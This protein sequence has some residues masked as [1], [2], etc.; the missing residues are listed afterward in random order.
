MARIFERGGAAVVTGAALGIGRAAALRYA[1]LG[2]QVVLVDLPSAELDEAGAAVAAIAGTSATLVVPATVADRAATATLVEAVVRRFGAPTVLMNNA[3]T[4]TGGSVL[5]DIAQWREA[6]EVN[7]WGVVNVV[8][9]FA[10][11]MIS[12]GRPAAIINVGS[13][14]GITN[15]PG[16]AAYN[17]TKAA[18]KSYT[19]QLAHHLRQGAGG[20]VTAHLLVPGWTT[21]GKRDHQ[22]GAWLPDQ[23]IDHMI[24]R[25]EQGSFYIVCPDGEVDAAMDAK[26]IVW[27]ALDITEDRPALSRWHGGF[28]AAF[29]AFASSPPDLATSAMSADQ[30]IAMLGLVPHPEGGAYRETFRDAEGSG[31]RSHSTAIYFLLRKGEVSRWHR[32]DAA[33]IWHHYSGAP[34][35]LS[36][37]AGDGV[38]ASTRSDITLGSAVATGARPQAIVPAGAW[39]Q[40]RSLGDW[41]LVGCT[42]A[43]AF[44][45]ERFELAPDGFEPPLSA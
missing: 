44:E 4:R 42:V 35:Q 27:S 20:A 16:N 3:V 45:F 18:L 26:R 8:D 5:G 39:Q 10:P 31:G 2:M 24:P 43:P 11:A 17:A 38:G 9:G 37:V 30:V 19:E 33:E 41:T 40:A 22:P 12:A 34:L 28:G 6:F 25:I 14:Q 1:N 23:V 7:L 13:K 15:P 32:V 36:V 29:E 21:T